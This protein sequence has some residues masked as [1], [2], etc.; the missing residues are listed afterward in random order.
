MR[1]VHLR[2]RW[3]SQHTIEVPDDAPKVTT[4]E[5]LIEYEDFDAS[6]ADLVDWEIS[7]DAD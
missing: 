6:G 3:E 5:E 1:N 4:L 2:A 7:D